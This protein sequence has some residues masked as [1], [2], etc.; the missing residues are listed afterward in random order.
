[1]DFNM[2]CGW[3]RSMLIKDE[4]KLP[5]YTE[6]KWPIVELEKGLENE[7]DYLNLLKAEVFVLNNV[8]TRSHFSEVIERYITAVPILN[9]IDHYVAD[10]KT[11]RMKRDSLVKKCADKWRDYTMKCR[12]ARQIVTERGRPYLMFNKI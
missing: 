4:K 3:E 6:V 7:I 11:E 8:Y 9:K 5:A 10:V 12:K 1:M 2:L